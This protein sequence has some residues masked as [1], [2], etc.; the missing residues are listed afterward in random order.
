M[1]QVP[2]TH[3]ATAVYRSRSIA[4]PLTD[5]LIYSHAGDDWKACRDYVR[6]RLGLPSWEPGD[7]QN[8][9]IPPKHVKKWDLAA[10]ESE[11]GLQPRTEDDLI[12]IERATKI[13]NEADNPRGSVA[14]KYLAAR[15]LEL[16]DDLSGPVLRYHG[17]TPWRDENSGQTIRIPCL[18][19]AFRSIDD[20]QHYGNTPHPRRSTGTLA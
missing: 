2:V 13:W 17:R 8:R 20:D 14:E 11:V 4:T 7:E 3:R 9:T 10:I 6:Q 1:P 19:A 15:C 18:I 16:P 5:F 12:R